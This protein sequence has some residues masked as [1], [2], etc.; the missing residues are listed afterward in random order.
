MTSSAPSRV[1]LG[2]GEGGLGD[3]GGLGWGGRGG[4]LQQAPHAAHSA[5]GT[6]SFTPL[7]PKKTAQQTG[8]ECVVHAL[9]RG[10]A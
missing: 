9:S 10:R 6:L 1:T 3:S 2:G 7:G 8:K 5:L 4:V